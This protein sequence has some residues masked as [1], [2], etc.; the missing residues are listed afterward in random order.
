MAEQ[1]S[2]QSAPATPPG[3]D[4]RP[5]RG[6][7][8]WFL[9]WLGLFAAGLGTHAAALLVVEG[10]DGSAVVGV[11]RPAANIVQMAMIPGW[12]VA[13]ILARLFA[14]SSMWSAVWANAAGAGAWTVVAMAYWRL[15]D[16]LGRARLESGGVAN[17][18][19]RRLL[20]DVPTAAVGLVGGAALARSALST[21]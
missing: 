8:R 9:L 12:A 11:V 20:L 19:R 16:R 5:R 3:G 18:A 6:R 15:R 7:A 13:R 14:P 1:G 21:Q 2:I 10:A 17:P 4:P